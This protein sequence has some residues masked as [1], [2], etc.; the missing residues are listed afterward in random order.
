[1]QIHSFNNSN[2]LNTTL[3]AQ[4]KK[5]LCE[6]VQLR[7]CAYLVVSGGQTPA[8]LFKILAQSEI[9]WEKVLVM[10]ADERCVSITD[11]DRNERLVRDIL[12]QH[13][14]ARAVFLSLY[15]EKL[16]RNASL[17]KVE[18][19]IAAIPVFD[20]VI[21]G[22]GEDGHTASLFPCSEELN[23]ALSDNAP[24]VFLINPKTAPH[25]RVSLSKNR[26]LQSEHIFLHFIGQK[27]HSVFKQALALDEPMIMP[28]SAFLNDINANVQVFYA[29]E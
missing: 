18:Q 25:Q 15:N 7:G 26:L 20:A 21:L 4:I 29:P 23:L 22:L 19:Q 14:A 2:L 10:L 3:A 9:P 5:I 28:V 24:S 6:A 13:Q 12:L 16:D 11:K 1:M 8:E 17:S 27:K